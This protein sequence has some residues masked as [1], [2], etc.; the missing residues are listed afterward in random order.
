MFNSAKLLS[1]EEAG[2]HRDHWN[3]FECGTD[4]AIQNLL[5]SLG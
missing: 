3:V 2:G 1:D 4:I 5:N